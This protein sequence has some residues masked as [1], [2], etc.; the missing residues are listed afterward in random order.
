MDRYLYRNNVRYCESSA[1]S[2]VYNGQEATAQKALR[3][4]ASVE[5][6]EDAITPLFEAIREEQT[7]MVK[8][9]LE[10]GAPVNHTAAF[11]RPPPGTKISNP[12]DLAT[13]S[14]LLANEPEISAF[15]PQ[16]LKILIVC[17][18]R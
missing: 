8:L 17:R 6:A 18:M 4:K 16:S 9:L 7:G 2:W 10:S 14:S 1:L 12:L 3:E 11:Y 15:A 13:R 5:A